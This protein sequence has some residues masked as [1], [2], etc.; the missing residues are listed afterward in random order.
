M[1]PGSSKRILADQRGQSLVEFAFSVLMLVLLML[2]IFEMS[3]M[4]LVYTTVANAARA[5]C[6]YGIVHGQLAGNGQSAETTQIQTVVTG[7]LSAAP[8][9]LGSPGLSIK[10]VYLPGPICQAAALAGNAP[11]CPV[12]VT[13]RYPYDPWVGFYSSFFSINISSTSEGVI[14]W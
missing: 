14:T 2:G 12:K 6:R 7:Y 3:R 11:G 9:N 8:I 4:L 13:V 5:G 1:T 10:V